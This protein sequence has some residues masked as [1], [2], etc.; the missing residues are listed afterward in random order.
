MFHG[1]SSNAMP[2]K[3][4]SSWVA[5]MGRPDGTATIDGRFFSADP[6]GGKAL[7]GWEEPWPRHGRRPCCMTMTTAQQKI[8][9][10]GQVL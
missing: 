10:G 4:A 3:E 7:G 6:E 9:K 1:G 8:E 2:R 5:R